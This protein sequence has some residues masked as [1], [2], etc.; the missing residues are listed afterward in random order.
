MAYKILRDPADIIDLKERLMRGEFP[1]DLSKKFGIGIASVHLWKNKFQ[2]AEPDLVFP[3]MKGQKRPSE[4]RNQVQPVETEPVQITDT[5]DISDTKNIVDTPLTRQVS[6][7]TEDTQQFAGVQKVSKA[8]VINPTK[9]LRYII[10]G[11]EMNI[12]QSVPVEI[13]SSA[14][15]VSITKD[16]IRIE[17]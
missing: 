16:T 11:V 12:P 7:V 6:D 8:P 15:H 3:R 14:K 9:T 2:K 10:N 17:F 5:A 13:D 4:V 1:V